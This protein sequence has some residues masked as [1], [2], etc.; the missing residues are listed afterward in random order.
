MRIEHAIGCSAPTGSPS[1]SAEGASPP[2]PPPLGGCN[3]GSADLLE[4]HVRLAAGGLI[5]RD[6]LHHEVFNIILH[7]LNVDLTLTRGRA[8]KGP[9][10]AWSGRCRWRGRATILSRNSSLGRAVNAPKAF[11][12]LVRFVGFDTFANKLPGGLKTLGGAG[13]L[14]VIHVN[15]HEKLLLMVYVDTF[16]ARDSLT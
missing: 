15:G 7:D 10:S 9:G 5:S 11:V 14:E 3:E 8:R 6:T 4:N 16:P 2:P 13:H 1:T 12:Y